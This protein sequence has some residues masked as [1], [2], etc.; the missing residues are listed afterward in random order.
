[1]ATSYTAAAFNSKNVGT[2]KP[3]QRDGIFDLFRD[4]KKDAGNYTAGTTASTAW[5]TSS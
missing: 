5:R 4:P 2:G 3:V 1:L